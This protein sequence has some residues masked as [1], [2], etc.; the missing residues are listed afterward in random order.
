MTLV[1]TQGLT[2]NY[3]SRL[4]VGEEVVSRRFSVQTPVIFNPKQRF[5]ITVLV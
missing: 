5:S 3:I 2:V 1:C 4:V